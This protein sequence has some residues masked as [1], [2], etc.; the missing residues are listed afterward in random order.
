MV[1]FF[2]KVGGAGPRPTLEETRSEFVPDSFETK[3]SG[4]INPGFEQK[5]VSGEFV[6]DLFEANKFFRSEFVLD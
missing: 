5:N 1:C 4:R 2:F 6:P 3:V